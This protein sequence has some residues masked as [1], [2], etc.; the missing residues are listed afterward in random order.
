MILATFR[1]KIDVR[2]IVVNFARQGNPAGV[3]GG[4][5]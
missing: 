4:M 1:R 3:I 2:S 5:H